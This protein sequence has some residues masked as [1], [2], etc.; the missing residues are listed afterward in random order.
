MWQ[1]VKDQKRP[2]NSL[3][4]DN[5][6]SGSKILR[7]SEILCADLIS[8][9]IP[10]NPEAPPVKATVNELIDSTKMTNTDTHA[11]KFNVVDCPLTVNSA[12]NKQLHHIQVT[13]GDLSNSRHE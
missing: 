5:D 2:G 6:I 4:P 13:T 8:P 7:N 11:P 3:I 9:D 1:E 12:T 10:R